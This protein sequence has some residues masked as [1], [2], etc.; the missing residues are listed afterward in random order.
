M[1]Y[2]ID[3]S[4]LETISTGDSNSIAFLEQLALDRRRCKNII[5]ANRNVLSQLANTPSLSEVS[6]K[7]YKVIGNRVSEHKLLLKH[8]KRYC[9][10]VAENNGTS[11]INNGGKEIFLLEI[12]E[13]VSKDFTSKSIMLA[14]NEEDILFYKLLGQYYILQNQMGNIK[15][16][17]EPRNGGGSTTYMVLQGILTSRD[18]MSLCIVDSDKKYASAEPRETMKKVQEIV[19]GKTR[20]HFDVIF[21]DVHEIENL[22]PLSVLE[23]IVEKLK[24]DDKGIEF[25]KFLLSQDASK[26][27][28]VFYY[29]VKKGI[30][31]TAYILEDDAD[32]ERKRKYRKLEEYR[33][34]WLPYIESFGVKI[35]TEND[36]IIVGVCD[37]TLKHALGYFDLLRSEKRMETLVVDSHLRETWLEIGE[38]VY[39]WGCVGGRI[40]V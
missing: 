2:E 10:I 1:I 14:E 32:D 6:R 22:L 27:S 39:C 37:K 21:L 4:C 26:T 9:R 40:A 3:E 15:I 12:N 30:P 23:D 38:K 20:D 18:R 31:R 7:I 13:A 33:K 24:I 16:D 8:A 11:I 17:F 34:Y 5:V 35:G 36:A 29:D 25:M 28:P 19:D